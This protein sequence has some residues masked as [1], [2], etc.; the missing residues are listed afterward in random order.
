[1]TDQ[2]STKPMVVV[3]RADTGAAG[4]SSASGDA[5]IVRLQK[6]GFRTVR[7]PM[8]A[9]EPVVRES[10]IRAFDAEAPFE[11]I[12]V[13][14]PRAA[15][16]ALEVLGVERLK[17]SLCVAPG[18]GTAEPLRSSGLNVVHPREGGTS[19][20]V[21]DLPE[22][23]ANRIRNQRVLVLAAPGGRTLI[24][25]SLAGRGAELRVLAPYHRRPL[26]PSGA[27]L[28]ALSSDRALVTLVSSPATLDRLK[29]ALPDALRRRWLA[30]RFVVSSERLA[31]RVR[32]LGAED[33][34]QAA[35]ASDDALLASL[36]TSADRGPRQNP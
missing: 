32:A 4:S 1:M 26:E 36:A 2:D 20:H 29:D 25:Q 14:S 27:L 31:E 19:E 3:T 24:A 12:I 28:D 22:L 16:V 35:G 8:F 17:D 5:L 34:V 6:A 18:P 11:R 33:I 13:T 15:D 23:A 30:G 9:L 10:L 7:A 21:L